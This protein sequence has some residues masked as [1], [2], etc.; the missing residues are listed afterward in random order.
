MIENYYHRCKISSS[1]INAPTRELIKLISEL[2]V[3]LCDKEIDSQDYSPMVPLI[4]N[5]SSGYDS[6]QKKIVVLEMNL[7]EYPGLIKV[8]KQFLF[9][10]H[11]FY[12]HIV[13]R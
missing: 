4:V 2:K 12:S 1:Y 8:K 11:P 3:K 10:D 5:D 9:K 13:F 7:N 6:K